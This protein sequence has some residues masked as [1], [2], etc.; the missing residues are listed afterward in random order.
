MAGQ[1]PSGAE[2]FTYRIHWEGFM[3]A[4]IGVMFLLRLL[5]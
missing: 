4:K 5:L 2:M 3:R 1:I